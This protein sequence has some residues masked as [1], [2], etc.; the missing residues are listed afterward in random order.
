MK[1]LL[2][3]ERQAHR[4]RSSLEPAG[5]LKAAGARL[6][7]TVGDGSVVLL[8]RTDEALMVCAAAAALREDATAVRRACVGRPPAGE[9]ERAVLVELQEPSA[10]TALLLSRAWPGL[11]VQVL[12]AG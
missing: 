9:N 5:A 6:A 10:S 4:R 11:D 1:D 8:A 12:P 3:E 7:G 2:D